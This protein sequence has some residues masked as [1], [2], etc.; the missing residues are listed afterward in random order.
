M[1]LDILVSLYKL[2]MCLKPETEKRK[3][4]YLNNNINYDVSGCQKIKILGRFSIKPWPLYKR[5]KQTL[6]NALRQSRVPPC[7]DFQ[8]TRAIYIAV[9]RFQL[10]NNPVV[11]ATLNCLSVLPRPTVQKRVF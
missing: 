8:L 3:K 7:K 2:G 11:S 5:C 4:Y 1:S 6:H 9:L 10:N